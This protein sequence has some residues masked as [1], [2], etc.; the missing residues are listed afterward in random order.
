MVQVADRKSFNYLG[1]SLSYY[2]GIEVEKSSLA[3]RFLILIANFREANEYFRSFVQ[4]TQGGIKFTI[5]RKP[6]ASLLR[7][8]SLPLFLLR[9]R[10][11]KESSKISFFYSAGIADFRKSSTGR[12]KIKDHFAGNLQLL[13]RCSTQRVYLRRVAERRCKYTLTARLRL[14][15]CLSALLS[16]MVK[17]LLCTEHKH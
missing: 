3:H 7:N 4:T 15:P 12:T 6:N 13:Y 5:D 2:L 17:L 16:L 8:F 9:E 1:I 14:L 10:R 11:S